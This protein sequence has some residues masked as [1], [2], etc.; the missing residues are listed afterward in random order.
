MPVANHDDFNSIPQSLHGRVNEIVQI[1]PMSH[2]IHREK[3]RDKQR[4]GINFKI[5]N[6][7]LNILTRLIVLFQYVI[8]FLYSVILTSN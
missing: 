3:R 2:D 4:G 7:I 1:P 8:T 5:L 6:L